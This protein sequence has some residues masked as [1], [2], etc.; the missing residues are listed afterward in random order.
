MS[1]DWS[2]HV[3]FIGYVTNVFNIPKKIMPVMAKQ[4]KSWRY[5]LINQKVGGTN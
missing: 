4:A 3:F 1:S 5:K 2:T